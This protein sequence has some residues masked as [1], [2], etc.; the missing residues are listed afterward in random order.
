MSLETHEPTAAPRRFAGIPSVDRLLRETGAEGLIERHGRE[1]V[2]RAVREELAA[3]R[4]ELAA[5]VATVVPT[6]RAILDEVARRLQREAQP[7]FA[8]SPQPHR[9]RP[10]HQSRPRPAA[11]GCDRGGEAGRRARA[12]WSTTWRRAARRPRR[13]RRGAAPPAH[14]RRG[15][16]GRQQ[17]RRRRAAGAEHAAA[18]R[19][20][21][22]SRG[23]LVEIGGSFRMPDDHRERR[24]PP[25]RGR[26]DQPHAPARL[27]TTAIGA[28]DRR[29]S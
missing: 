25:A 24:L 2:T 29:R 19:E 1:P 9:H 18:G 11:A 27:T 23:E 22:V 20:V 7:L 16:D 21:V 13:A 10:A 15:G 28:R 8:R 4:A 3:L 26:H 12:T 14:R 6:D 5:D 17:Q